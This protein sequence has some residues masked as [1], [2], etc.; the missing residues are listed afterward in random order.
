MRPSIEQRARAIGMVQAGADQNVVA[1]QL[2]VHK[3]TISRL[4]QKFRQTNTV[5]DR[6]RS[7]RPRATTLRQDRTIRLMHL[8]TVLRQQHELQW[9]YLDEKDQQ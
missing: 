9:R 4:V 5:N 6:P 7:G 2:G 8:K 3:S 1:R